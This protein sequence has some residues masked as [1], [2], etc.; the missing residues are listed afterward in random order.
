M[1]ILKRIIFND[2]EQR[3]IH[4]AEA[5]KV[6]LSLISTSPQILTVSEALTL[7][8]EILAANVRNCLIFLRTLGFVD[9]H[10]LLLRI[11]FPESEYD[12]LVKCEFAAKNNVTKL[13][14]LYNFK[15]VKQE[16]TVDDGKKGPVTSV[17]ESFQ[18]FPISERERINLFTQIDHMIMS[19]C[20]ILN[21]LHIMPCA[22]VYSQL[23][24]FPQLNPQFYKCLLD[25]LEAMISD[26]LTK[27]HSPLNHHHMIE[28]TCRTTTRY[29]P[30][31]SSRC[32][33]TWQHQFASC[34]GQRHPQACRSRNSVR[35][36]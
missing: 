26:K 8:N 30:P 32:C 12:N 18:D 15:Y 11:L 27:Y 20:Y 16:S 7:L 19:M 4:N 24:S 28:R 36:P 14:A 21:P 9:L 22:A 34:S 13:A 35:T 17:S 23:L 5:F 2:D 1:Q 31:T 33:V 3:V 29:T 10:I 6:L 25:R